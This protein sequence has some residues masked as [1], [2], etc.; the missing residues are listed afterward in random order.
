MTLDTA[1]VQALHRI[2]VGMRR[3]LPDP[4]GLA[5]QHQLREDLAIDVA[6]VRV[7]DVYTIAM[8]LDPE[9]LERV[10]LELFTDP[11]IQHSRAGAFLAG[12]FEYLIEV[13]FRPGVTDNVG[14]SSAEGI[15]DVLGRALQPDEAVYKSTQY[16][17]RG[18]VTREDCEHIARDL[19]ANDLIQRWVVKSAEELASLEASTLLGVP[20][21]TDRSE[22]T[23]RTIDLEIADDELMRLSRDGLLA[24]ELDEMQTIRDYFRRDEVRAL[25]QALA[26]PQQPNDIELEILAQTWSEH[27]KHK[28]FAAEIAY[29]DEHGAA[30]TVDGLFKTY[31]KGT[32]DAVAARIGWLV[33]VFHDNA[34]IIRFDDKHNFALKVETHN[35]PSALDPYGGAMTGIVGVNRDILGAGMGCKPIFNTDVFCFAPPD[36]SGHIPARLLHPRR[37]FRGVHAGVKDGG[38]ESGIPN[39]NGAIVFHERF[40]GKPLVFCG[41]GGLIPREVAGRP[42]HEKAARPGDRIVTVGGRIGKDGIHGA[43]F[44]SEELHE[45]SPATAVQI[46]DPI[47]Q[48]KM[49]DFL[50]EAR[51]LGLF[52]AITDNGAGGLSSSVGEMAKEPGGAEVHLERAPLKYPGLASWEIFLSEAQERMTLAVPPESL[53][54]FMGLAR[55]R[56]VEATDLGTFTDTGRLECFYDGTRICALEMSFLHEGVPRMHLAAQWAPPKLAPEIIPGDVDYAAALKAVLGALNVCSKES[57]VRMYD[58]EVQGQSV[59]KQFQGID[60]DGPGDAGVIR[61]VTGSNRGIAVACG[62]CPKYSDI[63]TYA[64]MAAAVDE[65]V[66]NLICVGARIG[67]IA[68]LDN[69]CWPDPVQSD[70]T[71]D[72]AYKLGQL[73]RCCEALREVCLAY[74]IPLISGKDSMKNDYKIGDTKIS[75]PPTVLFTAAAIIEDVNRVVTMEVKSAGDRVY[76]LGETR[77]EMGGSE[78][79]ALHSQLG[80]SVPRVDPHTAR[81]LYER[82]SDAIARGL[83]ASCHDCSDGGLGVA[84]A[85]SAFAGGFGMDLD[86]RPLKVGNDVAALFSESQSRFVVTVAPETKEA[87]ESAMK[88]TS[89]YHVGAVTEAPFLKVT[90]NG[91]PLMDVPISE[92]KEA[93]QQTLRW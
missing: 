78:Y 76:V 43:T 45:G 29:T 93:W 71:P 70:K 24:L 13:G 17:L 52:S 72:G 91:G 3:E 83:V 41:T 14:R 85:E 34:G 22:V 73:V 87:F 10:R 80:V 86:L 21:V 23:V 66:R 89:A 77:A 33:S 58:H 81:A 12:D 30:R 53:D 7:I 59:L 61:P 27:C 68:G 44:S 6:S 49:T 88:H 60:E 1:R 20:V 36:Y 18:G 51:D 4:A 32:T 92:L 19:L 56:S 54:D 55:A 31:I 63:D 79:L 74:D 84:L 47:T 67:M 82:L 38:N 75:I 62:I 39:V 35:S 40:L 15:A 65:A 90:G 50:L 37:V 16:L 64:M 9:E 57:F 8:P 28:I 48:K 42:S 25:R 2:E 69:F 26:M 5:L 11:V 46:G